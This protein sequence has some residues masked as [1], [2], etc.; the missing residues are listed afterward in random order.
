MEAS[1]E[2]SGCKRF[3]VVLLLSLHVFV[4]GC[5]GGSANVLNL[6]FIEIECESRGLLPTGAS[7]CLKNEISSTFCSP[8]F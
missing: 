8:F 7:V 6:V 2:A 5:A 4:F 1:V 3:L